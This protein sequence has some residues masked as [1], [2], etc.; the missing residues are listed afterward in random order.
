M[1][2]RRPI[3][4]PKH[5]PDPNYIRILDTTLRDGEQSPGAS[6]TPKEKLHIARQLAKLGVDII[7]AGFLLPRYLRQGMGGRKVCQI[8]ENTSSE[9]EFLYEILCEVIKAGA[10]TIDIGDIGGYC[11]PREFGQFIVDIKDNTPGIENVIIRVH[12][13]NDL[14]LAVA[15]TLEGVFAGARQVEVTING[16]GERP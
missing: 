14:G 5:I 16:I 6:M 2:S 12:C 11:L 1:S 4:I 8:P 10:T 3:Y 13:H 7:E 9:R 15:N